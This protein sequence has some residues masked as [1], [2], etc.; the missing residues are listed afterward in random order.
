M[1]MTWPAV[2]PVLLLF[3]L[4]GLGFQVPAIFHEEF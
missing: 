4:A 1:F 3:V 2:L